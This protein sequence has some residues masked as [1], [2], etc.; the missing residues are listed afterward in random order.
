MKIRI[1]E[2]EVT[3]VKGTENIF[4]ETIKNFHNLKKEMPIKVLEAYRTLNGLNQ[5]NDP[6]TRNN[7]KH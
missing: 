5:K 1:E 2:A 7:Q 6:L 4:N 3:E